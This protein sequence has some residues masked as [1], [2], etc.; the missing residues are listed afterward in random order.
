MTKSKIFRKNKLVQLQT[1]K[2]K[3]KM[4]FKMKSVT[5]H[6]HRKIKTI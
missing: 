3:D 2:Y 6:I 1:K 5:K 4:D